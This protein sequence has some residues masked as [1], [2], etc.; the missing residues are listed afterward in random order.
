MASS[1]D[2]F[3]SHGSPDK[4]WVRT[5]VA[6]L[7]DRGLAV[8]LDEQDLQPGQNWV[9]GLSE[10]LRNS[11]A[12]VLVLSRHTLERPWV[13][14]EWTSYLA[15]HG[16]RQIIVPVI[17]E[18]ANLPTFLTPIQAIYALDRDARRV[19]GQIAVALGR[20]G[21]D[22]H[23]VLAQ[24]LS[25]VIEPAGDELNVTGGDGTTRTISPP[26]T[27]ANDFTVAWLGYQRLTQVSL[28]TEAQRAELHSHARTLGRLLFAILF[29]TD[30]ERHR[31]DHATLA[32]AYRPLVTIRSD[33]DFLL[34]LPWELLWHAD[35]F[36]VR[37]GV[38]DMVRST[39]DH[40][41][42][43][44]L[45]PEPTAPFSLVT[46]VSAPQGSHLNYEVESYRITRAL[47]AYCPQT[48]TELGTLADLV[49]TV[50]REK[51]IGIHFSGHGTPGH[52]VFEDNFGQEDAVPIA[53][54]VQE[55]TQRLPGGQLPTFFYLA[56]CHGNTPA[57]TETRALG[58][59]SAAAQLHRAGVTQVVGYYGPIAD[60][61]STRAEEAFYR[62]IASG[63]TTSH[64]VRQALN[65][66]LAPFDDPEAMHKPADTGRAASV[67]RDGT[68]GVLNHSHPYAWA[69]LVFYHRGP[70]HPLSL[71]LPERYVQTQ[72]ARLQRSYAGTDQRRILSTGFIG[73]RQELHHFRWAMRRGQRV[74]VFQGLG[75]LGK[76]TLAFK[77]FPI[78]TRDGHDPLLTIWCQ[79]LEPADNLARELTNQLSEAAQGL[80]GEQWRDVV[81]TV[82]QMS[83][84]AE[85]QRF[86]SFLQTILQS[87]P[88]LVLYLD[89]LESL[90][91]GPDDED[92]EAFGAWRSADL[93]A[94][95]SIL[96]QRSGDKLSVVASCRYRHASFEADTLHVPEM[97][98]AA[99]FRMMGWFEGLRRLSLTNRAFL[100]RLLHGHPQAVEFLDD[101]IRDAL[102]KWESRH[103]EWA[104][105]RTPEGI[106]DEWQHLIAP[107]LPDVE[108][109]LRTNLLFDAIWHQVLDDRCR[110][111]LFRMTLLRRPWDWDLM[112]QLGDSDDSEGQ[113]E[114]VAEKL[115]ATSLLGEV[116]ERHEAR[117][118]RLFQ[119]HPTTAR[120]ITERTDAVEA[121][122]LTQGTYL[123][124]G[125]YL[126]KVVKTSHELRD[127]L[128][129][130]YYLFAA[131]EFDRAYEMLSAASHW[132]Q[133]RG[134]VRNGLT[135][136][137]PFEAV[138]KQLSPERKERLLGTLGLSY[139][140]LGQVK[141]AIAHFEQS[142]AIS[143][144]IGDL[145]DEGNALGNLG[146]AYRALGENRKAIGYFEQAL[147][148]HREIGDRQSEGAGLSNLGLVYHAL[149]EVRESIAY[150]EQALVISREIGDRGGE[151][152]A[153]SNLGLAYYA[154]GEVRESIAYNEQGLVISR[155]IGDRHTESTILSNL[156]RAYAHLRENRKAITYNE[157]ALVIHREIGDRRGEGNALSNLGFVY[158][159]LGDVRKVITYNEQALVIRREI[160][161]RRGEGSDLSNLGFAY[162]ILGEVRESI[163]YFEQGLVISREIGDRQAEGTILGNLGSAYQTLGDMEK[164][165]ALWQEALTKCLPETPEYKQVERWLQAAK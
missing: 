48:P 115:R 117:W 63:E 51:P 151:G 128:D 66:M 94:I 79:E 96:K 45:L 38:V 132:L 163:A 68:T 112:M 135:I 57:S 109:Q 81:Q 3:L 15:E 158:Y 138:A 76:S 47:S 149:G 107:A 104:T 123:R 49:A 43:E 92:P 58:S 124:V 121:H 146:N 134:M 14:R 54:L 85:P 86:G 161:D 141:L 91:R 19:A 17:L 69:Q 12:F 80:F 152:S 6:E 67:V 133:G 98:N 2:V 7:E 22:R 31:F 153:L 159:T 18:Q 27:Q 127:H 20:S 16:P 165:K 140:R 105:P 97:D 83:E 87:V 44:S 4:P 160:G 155:E 62:A 26:W 137:E 32:G 150:S 61:L 119:N 59:E 113:T 72:E 114:A 142:L 101:L 73:R 148:I 25:F 106:Q 30:E 116:Q 33:D 52:L 10:A 118:V 130:G 53:T 110:H 34:S 143:R 88:H 1:S 164:A 144:E 162:F 77:A 95:W 42:V 93:H 65:A 154:L 50:A 56:S 40:V 71:K 120:F 5:L 74:F 8:F 70:D 103:G 100:V 111:M 24:E 82:D 23:L 13:E 60:E 108:T 145:Q 78:L 125:T 102:I 131:G 147:V 41:G 90:L 37:D 157:Q 64:A 39:A 35:R 21:D 122:A 89:N 156:G 139:Y 75:G 84:A 11:R 55:L 29:A 9:L 126:E 129:A 28:E 46:N 136:L 36:L 99:I